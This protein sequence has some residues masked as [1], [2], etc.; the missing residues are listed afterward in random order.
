MTADQQ[1]GFFLMY[2]AMTYSILLASISSLYACLPLVIWLSKDWGE[3]YIYFVY[4][5]MI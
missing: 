2:D 5:L 4:L 1:V 3:T